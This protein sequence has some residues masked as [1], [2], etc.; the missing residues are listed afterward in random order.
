VFGSGQNQENN[1]NAIG[2][3]AV[4][5]IRYISD[6]YVLLLEVCQQPQSGFMYGDSWRSTTASAGD[7][8]PAQKLRRLMLELAT[9]SVPKLIVD[10][11]GA[12]KREKRTHHSLCIR[13][14]Y[15]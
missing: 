5:L 4:R 7:N 15:L 3:L 1:L 13:Y 2:I 6:I 9:K 12:T 14:L 11:R 8:R 10:D